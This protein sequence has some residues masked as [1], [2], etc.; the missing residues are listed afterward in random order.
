[1]CIQKDRGGVKTQAEKEWV[2]QKAWEGL[3]DE[4]DSGGNHGVEGRGTMLGVLMEI[5]RRHSPW[6]LYY[7]SKGC[8]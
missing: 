7:N 6:S 5:R 3:Y 2:E 1:M 4:F 8:Q